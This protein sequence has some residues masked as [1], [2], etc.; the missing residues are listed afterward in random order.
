[1][2]DMERED[3]LTVERKARH[4]AQV[5]QLSAPILAALIVDTRL[6]E[7]RHVF[8]QNAE[9]ALDAAEILIRKWHKRF[10]HDEE[11]FD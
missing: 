2:L 11:D 9:L 7:M 6:D 8:S 10:D 3:L 1:M 5:L 4:E